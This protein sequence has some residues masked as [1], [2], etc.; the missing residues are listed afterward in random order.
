MGK[1]HDS[2]LEKSSSKKQAEK[3]VSKAEKAV[4]KGKT[5]DQAGEKS[6]AKSAVTSAKPAPIRKPKTGAISL[7][8]I[9]LRAYYVAET[10]HRE[11]RPGDTHS[12]WLEAERQLRA[13]KAG[14]TKT[15]KTTK[16]DKGPVKA[17]KAP[18]KKA[19]RKAG[20]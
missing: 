12:D 8:D 18:A 14:T 5:K 15:T 20:A 10:R 4:S 9:Q 19:T 13:E 1:K 2:K 16:T 11:G 7:A 6:P 3:A 17:A